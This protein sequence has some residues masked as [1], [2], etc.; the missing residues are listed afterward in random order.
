VPVLATPLVLFLIGAK[1]LP[2]LFF[3]AFPPPIRTNL[4][5]GIMVHC[6]SLYVNHSFGEYPR[7][8]K[9]SLPRG[10]MLIS[11]LLIF[12]FL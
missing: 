1:I 7:R 4:V 8:F 11:K 5:V 12:L 9:A 3:G 10:E 2:L 6:Y